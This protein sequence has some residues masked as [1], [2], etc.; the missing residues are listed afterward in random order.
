[1][2][3]PKIEIHF[4]LHCPRRNQTKEFGFNGVEKVYHQLNL[5]RDTANQIGF[6]LKNLG[7]C[8]LVTPG[9]LEELD[10]GGW[11]Q[12]LV[13]VHGQ[14]WSFSIH[15]WRSHWI[16]QFNILTTKKPVFFFSSAGNV[17]VVFSFVGQGFELFCR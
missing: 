14:R 8:L 4:S 3:N 17:V 16:D 12:C 9:S 2:G 13:V 7:G 11:D 6:V 5:F 15:A 10:V 1:M